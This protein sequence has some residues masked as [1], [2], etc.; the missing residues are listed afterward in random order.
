MYLGLFR[1]FFDICKN[2][3][4]E[5]KGGYLHCLKHFCGSEK[6][7]ITANTEPKILPENFI[8]HIIRCLFEGSIK[9][10]KNEKNIPEDKTFV[11]DYI[12]YEELYELRFYYSEKFD[13]FFLSNIVPKGRIK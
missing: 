9:S 10:I 4:E 7:P 3:E 1:T 11:Y 13:I 2:K 6:Q 12:I 5:F 8:E